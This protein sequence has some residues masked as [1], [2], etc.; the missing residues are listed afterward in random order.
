MSDRRAGLIRHLTYSDSGSVGPDSGSDA[1]GSV[2]LTL[3]CRMT[4]KMQNSTMMT[5]ATAPRAPARGPCVGKKSSTA[6][7][8]TPPIIMEAVRRATRATQVVVPLVELKS[9]S[10]LSTGGR[11]RS[12]TGYEDVQGDYD[13]LVVNGHSSSTRRESVWRRDR[14]RVAP[15]RDKECDDRRIVGRTRIRL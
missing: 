12:A 7:R 2:S 9:V 8:K 3:L 10:P 4:T 5:A 14:V 13:F 6:K 15:V 1:L 11:R